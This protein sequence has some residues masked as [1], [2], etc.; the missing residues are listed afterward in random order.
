IENGAPN[1]RTDPVIID[2]SR[3]VVLQKC[4][5]TAGENDNPNIRAI[6]LRNDAS[7]NIIRENF[8]VMLGRSLGD[9]SGMTTG[10]QIEVEAGCNHNHVES[11][12]RTSLVIDTGVPVNFSERT[13]PLGQRQVI[14][15]GTAAPTSGFWQRGDIV[16]NTQPSPS[17]FIGWVCVVGGDP[18]R[19]MW[20]TFGIISA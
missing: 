10:D 9:G 3:H 14:S 17:G 7:N 6:R 13:H 1:S 19:M 18:G 16:L 2:H 4:H 20:K 12:I 11:N 15:Y 5:I 8:I